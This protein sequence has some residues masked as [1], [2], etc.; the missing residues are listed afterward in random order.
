MTTIKAALATIAA[1]KVSRGWQSSVFSV[2][3]GNNVM[4]ENFSAHIQGKANQC[5]NIGIDSRVGGDV[6]SIIVGNVLGVVSD[7]LFRNL[8]Q[9]QHS[10]LA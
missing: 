3:V 10:K 9:R 2:P 8:A 4:A 1:R 7:A 6:L 5:F